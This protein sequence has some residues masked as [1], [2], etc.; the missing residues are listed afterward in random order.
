MTDAVESAT[1]HNG[2]VRSAGDDASR[3]VALRHAADLWADAT[4]NAVS[5]RRQD[6]L[7]DKRKVVL[8]FF[9]YVKKTPAEVTPLDVK[10]W[11]S[12]LESGGLAPTTVY[13]WLC[14]VSSFY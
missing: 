6:I 9:D 14:H 5:P 13:C 11:Q 10:D 4:T 12:S 7:R 8:S 3:S 1:G 2:L